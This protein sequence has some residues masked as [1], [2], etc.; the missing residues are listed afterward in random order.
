MIF[1][2]FPGKVI[3]KYKGKKIRY[4]TFEKQENKNFKREFNVCQTLSDRSNDNRVRYV[5]G[6]P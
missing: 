3:T 2:Y 6:V 4:L 1:R 5:Q